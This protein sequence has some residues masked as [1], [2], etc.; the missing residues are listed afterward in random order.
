MKYSENTVPAGYKCGTCGATGCK[1]WR[2]SSFC[3]D[4]KCAPCA[5]RAQKRSIEGIDES[6]LIPTD[7]GLCDQ[8][9]WMVPCVPTEDES[10]YWGYTSV[11]QDGVEWWKRLPTLPNK[12]A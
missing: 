6:G 4:L 2:D 12:G 9:G 8:I 5:A 11:P 10:T 1:L 7:M 3:P